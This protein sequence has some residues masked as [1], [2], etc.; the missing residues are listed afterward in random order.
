MA[1]KQAARGEKTRLEN[2]AVE[3]PGGHA[4]QLVA[5][6]RRLERRV[7]GGVV[8]VPLP[9]GVRLVL[10]GHHGHVGVGSNVAQRRKRCDV[11][12][13]GKQQR[14]A[15]LA[16]RVPR[17]QL[18]ILPRIAGDASLRREQQ[19]LVREGLVRKWPVDWDAV[20]HCGGAKRGRRKGAAHHLRDDRA[21]DA[22]RVRAARRAGNNVSIEVGIRRLDG[23]AAQRDVLDESRAID[24]RRVEVRL[25]HERGA[26]GAA[27]KAKKGRSSPRSSTRRE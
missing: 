21:R 2:V 7:D 14:V 11:R 13:R 9:V 17:Q 23:Q 15:S 25:R 18:R 12:L 24:A 3:A 1:L 27:Q 16:V 19:I 20:G 6:A 22:R 8:A 26:S 10:R 5:Q 4:E